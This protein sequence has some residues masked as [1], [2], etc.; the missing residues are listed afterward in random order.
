MANRRFVSRPT[1]RRTTWEGVNIDISDLVVGTPQT[2]TVVSE[3]LLENFPLPTIV[4]IRG[5]MAAIT[6]ASSTPGGFG[7]VSMGMIL[8]TETAFAAGAIP[9]PLTDIGDDWIWWDQG[10]IGSQADDVIGGAVTID[11][12]VV[13]SKAMR[14]VQINLVLVFRCQ[15]TTSE[16]VMVA[17][18][19]G[20]IR[21]LL[22]AP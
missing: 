1:K 2:T 11:R 10:I 8:V 3:A 13:D 14:K 16:S 4:R 5:R 19:T 18:I 7:L 21:V 15:L 20:S 22:K 12:I 9:D 17:N 6:D